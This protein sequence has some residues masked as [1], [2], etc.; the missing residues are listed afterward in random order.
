MTAFLEPFAAEIRR[1]L[2]GEA[3]AFFAAMDAPHAPALRVNT[4]REG[5]RAL[6]EP[7]AGSPVIWCPSGHY[8]RA[9]TRPG[10]SIAHAAGCLYLQDA[11]A[12]APAMALAPAPGER[13]L[14]L[15]AAPGGKA[16]QMAAMLAGEGV[17]VANEPDGARAKILSGN[18]E[19]LGAANAL[20]T[21]APPEALAARWPGFFDAVLVD[22]PCSGEGM[23]R[24]DPKTLLEWRP[25]APAGC[26]A[27]QAAIL[28]QAALLVRPGGRLAYST[29]TFNELENER[30]I[31]AF[32]ARHAE[33][34]PLPFSLPGVG[35]AKAGMLR[36]WP[37]RLR[38]EGHFVALLRRTGEAMPR[39]LHMPPPHDRRAPRA[40]SVEQVLRLLM[41]AAGTPALQAR[42]ARFALHLEGDSL[43][44]RAPEAPDLLGLAAP[45]PGLR[46]C[47]I[48][49]DIVRPNHALAMAI[50]PREAA[51]A[52]EADEVQALRYL[53]GEALEADAS[54]WTL[55][56]HR[57][58]PLGWAKGS[59]GALKNHLPKGLRQ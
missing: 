35:E 55:V 47:E 13:V 31:E 56:V 12:M 42:L 1:L 39:P 49:K 37:H 9:G 36:L 43:Y 20:I 22:A 25:G 58:A 3:E 19:R 38:G 26:A 50:S 48:S 41:E 29:C 10:H 54:G 33:F 23:F 8:V 24:R 52:F 44:A 53:R 5:A 51:R 18:L 32:L 59:D 21:C 15:C 28:T 16:G 30:V 6:C 46:L 14:D 57:G 34:A 4:L 40:Q 17:L 7:F 2:G 45:R 11:S 27:R